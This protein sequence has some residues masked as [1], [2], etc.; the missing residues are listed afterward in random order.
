[1][2][3]HISLGSEYCTGDYAIEKTKTHK[4]YLRKQQKLFTSLSLCVF[5]VNGGDSSSRVVR[6]KLSECLA[7]NNWRESLPRS[8]RHLHSELKC[9]YLDSASNV[10]R[11][12]KKNMFHVSMRNPL[13]ERPQKKNFKFIL[14][15]Q[16]ILRRVFHI[17]N[18]HTTKD[19]SYITLYCELWAQNGRAIT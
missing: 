12:N 15:N 5:H 1:M 7:R 16:Q 4:K 9:W 13:N 19:E 2:I 18:S 10:E 3:D 14:F 8:H 17:R 11:K 6:R